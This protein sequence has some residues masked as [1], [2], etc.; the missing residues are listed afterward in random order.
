MGTNT[1]SRSSVEFDST[2]AEIV[3]RLILMNEELPDS[4]YDDNYV[5]TCGAFP[6]RICLKVDSNRTTNH[7]VMRFTAN[8]LT[9]VHVSI[10]LNP[11]G[12]FQ[13]LH[14]PKFFLNRQ[15]VVTVLFCHVSNFFFLCTRARRS[16]VFF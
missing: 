11:D 10:K 13:S 12:R 8:T 2:E 7:T 5:T 15:T 1:K 9:S 16:T 14:G 4:D 6:P 3:A